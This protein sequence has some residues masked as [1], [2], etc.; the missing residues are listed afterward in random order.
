MMFPEKK[1]AA[2]VERDSPPGRLNTGRLRSV[3]L[4]AGVP[5]L[6]LRANDRLKPRPGFVS[7]ARRHRLRLRM[8]SQKKWRKRLVPLR[9]R[10]LEIKL[11]IFFRF[12]YFHA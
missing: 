3:Q 7:Y 9:R 2:A 11:D 8:S 12:W 10:I 5:R 4:S 6:A 1:I